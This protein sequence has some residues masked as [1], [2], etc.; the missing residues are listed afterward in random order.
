[1]SDAC[2]AQLIR[3]DDRQSKDQGSNPGTVK[4]VSFSTERFQIFLIF[5][6]MSV[7][8]VAAFEKD[9]H[10]TFLRTSS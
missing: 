9:F 4:G 3:A 6:L 8:Q 10:S 5:I 7:F 1:M 2:V